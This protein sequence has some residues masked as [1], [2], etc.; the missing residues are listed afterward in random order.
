MMTKHLT[1]IHQGMQVSVQVKNG[2]VY[3]GVLHTCRPEALFGLVLRHCTQ[4]KPPTSEKPHKE[5]MSV[6]H[7]SRLLSS[8]VCTYKI[9]LYCCERV[10][11]S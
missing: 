8:S 2:A 7:L 9:S 10:Y 3:E 4:I 5:G 6:L 11:T 1:L